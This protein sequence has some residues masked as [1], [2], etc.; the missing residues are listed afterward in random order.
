[1]N[2][3][4][5]G[6]DFN[7]KELHSLSSNYDL[8]TECQTNT[9]SPS[10]SSVHHPAINGG[11][12]DLNSGR[13]QETTTGGGTNG[14]AD[15]VGVKHLIKKF[16]VN[17]PH[18]P[19]SMHSIPPPVSSSNHRD[20][21]ALRSSS[22]SCRKSASRKKQQHLA[23]TSMSKFSNHSRPTSDDSEDYDEYSGDDDD[24]DNNDEDNER[25]LKI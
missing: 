23:M 14:D 22:A 8:L 16:N 1:M 15:Y 10:S 13:Q 5:E 7:Y 20:P 9:S 18:P 4:T 24:D 6:K 12:S 19:H 3:L 11:Q 17:P 25:F 2:L 21:M